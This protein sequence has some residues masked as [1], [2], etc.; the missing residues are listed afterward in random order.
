MV[1]GGI[2]CCLC[3][4][5]EMLMFQDSGSDSNGY[6]EKEANGKLQQWGELSGST[7]TTRTITFPLSFVNLT[8]SLIPEGAGSGANYF[9]LNFGEEAL[10]SHGGRWAT[11]PGSTSN[12]IQW[13]ENGKSRT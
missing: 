5:G 13:I 7:S 3:L 2:V 4:F 6:Y 11:N 12:K 10:G 9:S 1:K 8:Y